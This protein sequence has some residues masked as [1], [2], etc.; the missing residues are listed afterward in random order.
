[1]SEEKIDSLDIQIETSLGSD[2]AQQISKASSAIKRMAENLKDVDTSRLEKLNS[3]FKGT[4]ELESY[5][6]SIKTVSSSIKSL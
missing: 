4:K 6:K 1:M 3:L 5:A 2:T